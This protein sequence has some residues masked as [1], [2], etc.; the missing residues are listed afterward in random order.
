MPQA[1]AVSQSEMFDSQGEMFS[2]AQ[3][4]RSSPVIVS[5]RTVTLAEKIRGAINAIKHQVVT[6]RRYISIAWSGGQFS[7]AEFGLRCAA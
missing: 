6:E 7:H 2:A 3:V 1:L 5:D 4:V